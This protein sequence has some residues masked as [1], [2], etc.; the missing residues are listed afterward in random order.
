MKAI[1]KDRVLIERIK[2]DRNSVLDIL[3]DEDGLLVGEIILH[4]EL[5]DGLK[6]GT[7]IYF[8]KSEAQEVTIE[9]KNLYILLDYNVIG[10]K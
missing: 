7:Q 9:G 6:P 5:V 4:G 8:R 2:E 1:R 3:E 10:I